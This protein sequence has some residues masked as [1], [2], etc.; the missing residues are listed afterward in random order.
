MNGPVIGYTLKYAAKTA[1]DN[2][3]V[4][5]L[6]FEHQLPAKYPPVKRV[7]RR[8]NAGEQPSPVIG[9]ALCAF[10]K[11]GTPQCATAIFFRASFSLAIIR[12]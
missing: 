2:G 6:R 12:P 7:R 4:V 9:S 11:L 3:Q 1:F 10:L 8:L 5:E